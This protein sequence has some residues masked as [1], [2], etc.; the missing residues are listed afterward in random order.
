M[1][2]ASVGC[3]QPSRTIILRACRAAGQA[4]ASR[5]GGT[6]LA[7]DDGSSGRKARP[8]ATPNEKSGP[9]RNAK[10]S[11]RRNAPSTKPRGTFFS[12]TSRPMST[13][14]PYCTPEGQV[15]SQARQV[16]QR[17]RWT[18]VRTVTGAPSKACFMR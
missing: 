7:S 8:I 14:R 4:P 6:C 5:R 11:S 10:R 2:G 16:R 3:T 9:E 15:V 12:T 1:S 18:C 17:S 13:S